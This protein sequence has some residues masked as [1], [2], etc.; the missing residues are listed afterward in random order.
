MFGVLFSYLFS[1][2]FVFFAGIRFV[3]ILQLESYQNKMFNKWIMSNIH[4]RDLL[5]INGAALLVSIITAVVFYGFGFYGMEIIGGILCFCVAAYSYFK[6]YTAP[7]KKPL[8]ITERVKRLLISYIIVIAIVVFS[9][10]YL[11]DCLYIISGVLIVLSPYLVLLANLAVYP[12]E[13]MIKKGLL[14][15]AKD[16]LKSRDDLIKIGITGSFGKTSTKF[17]L[18]TILSEKYNSLCSPASYNTPMGL[19]RVIREMLTKDHE[20]FIAEMGARYTKDIKELCELV[21]PKYGLI[22]SIGKQHLETFK[23]LENIIE[24]KYDL[25]RSLPQDGMGYLPN[26]GDICTELAKRKDGVNKKVYSLNE[27]SK[28]SVY[29]KDI[30]IDEIGSSFDIVTKD[31]DSIR[32][33]TCLLGEHNVQNIL[34][35]VAVALDLGLTLEEIKNGIGKIKPIEHRLQLIDSPSGV[36]VIDDAFNAN[37]KGTKMALKVLESF[38]GKKIIVTPGLVELGDETEKL[39]KEFGKD[40]AKVCDVVVLVG[41]TFSGY[42]KDGLKEAGFDDGAIV[43]Y[44]TL[45]EVTPFIGAYCKSG[46]VVLFEN[47]LPDNYL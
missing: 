28:A 9:L 29:A 30:T 33:N 5:I 32:V 35:C 39:N 47:D 1:V 3:H 24:T 31:G 4:M 6:Y 43:E 42:I 37:P 13:E 40:I 14:S 11:V 10:S 17:I 19:T 36:I 38:K 21:Q 23:S 27:I 2:L 16:I 22:S 45:D 25:I 20:V 34:G 18:N 44:D 15:E 8:V 46:D 12:I 26:D 7:K 41:K